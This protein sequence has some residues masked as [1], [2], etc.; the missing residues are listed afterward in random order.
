MKG[1]MTV[2]LGVSGVMYVANWV[3][4]EAGKGNNWTC[5]SIG[6]LAMCL[7]F[8]LLGAI[9]LDSRKK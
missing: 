6:V 7:G 2:C 3:S 8:G 5:V 1:L 4:I 9:I